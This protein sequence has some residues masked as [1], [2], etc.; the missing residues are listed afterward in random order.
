MTRPISVRTATSSFTGCNVGVNPDVIHSAGMVTIRGEDGNEATVTEIEWRDAVV[1][2][3]DTVQAFYDASPPREPL[4]DDFE[5]AG[6]LAF[7]QEWRERR[8]AA[9]RSGK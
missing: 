2:F 7:W 1:A 4:D 5:D 9:L 8:A 3:V 6:W